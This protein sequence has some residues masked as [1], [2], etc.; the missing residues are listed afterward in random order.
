MAKTIYDFSKPESAALLEPVDD[1]VMGGVS[2]SSFTYKGG[3]TRFWGN[4]SLERGG[5]FASVRSEVGETDLSRFEGLA[6]RSRGDGKVYQLRL[7][8]DA[9]KVFYTAEFES[10]PRWQTLH[11]PFRSFLPD[12]RGQP[13]E[14]APELNTARIVTFGLMIANAQ[15]GEFELE[16]ASLTAYT[17]G[18]VS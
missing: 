6:L 17:A 13:V 16:L 1:A 18:D 7:Q 15:A 14:D 3:F 10:S 8:T 9:A 12:Y 2:S 5:G 4:L 11:L